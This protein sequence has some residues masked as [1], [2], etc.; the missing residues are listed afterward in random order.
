[1]PLNTLLSQWPREW[2]NERLYFRM[3]L[4]PK[5]KYT[6]WPIFIK[7]V[8]VFFDTLILTHNH[9]YIL[10]SKNSTHHY[11]KSCL[12]LLFHF[13]GGPSPLCV[14]LSPLPVTVTTRIVMFLVGDPYKPSFPLLLGGG[15]TQIMRL[16][17]ESLNTGRFSLAAIVCCPSRCRLV[18]SF[19]DHRFQVGGTHKY[20]QNNR[21]N[22]RCTQPP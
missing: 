11:L 10:Y 22:W 19:G 18:P 8:V 9:I 15:T 16:I 6:I 14:G 4:S 21:H 20:W 1:M 5:W 2:K 3:S 7:F 17:I 13:C 12:K